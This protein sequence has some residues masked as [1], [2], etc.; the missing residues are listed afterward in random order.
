M[1]KNSVQTKKGNKQ[2]I[3]TETLS[4]D[5]EIR[6]LQ[7]AILRI[8]ALIAI[9]FGEAG[10]EILKEN[11][12]SEQGLN[13]MIPGKKIQ[14]VF[15]FCFIKNFTEINEV[16]QEKTILFVNTIADIVHSS[17]DKFQGVCNKS[18]C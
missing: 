18:T 10:G 3:D 8:S 4:V 6:T 1:L 17:V 13:P 14:S 11:I 5:Y 9:G 12:N 7:F 2:N 15:G 16:L